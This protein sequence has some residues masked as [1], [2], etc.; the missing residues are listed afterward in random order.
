MLST[1]G[2]TLSGTARGRLGP[3]TVDPSPTSTMEVQYSTVPR[4]SNLMGLPRFR[5]FG[6]TVEIVNNVMYGN[7]APLAGS[8]ARNENAV[9]I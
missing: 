5:S 4:Y 6:Y 7:A 9:S 2:E 8:C 3:S 1:N